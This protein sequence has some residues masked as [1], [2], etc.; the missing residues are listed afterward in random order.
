MSTAPQRK[1]GT[2]TLRI[3]GEM[4][5]YRAAELKPVLLAALEQP[6]TLDVDLSAVT[7]L[8][9]SGVQLLMMAKK[10]AQQQGQ[11]LQLLAHSPAVLDV[12]ELLNLAA[13][14][15]DPLVIA[16]SPMPGRA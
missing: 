8:D 11:N 15:G 4:T 3:E 16:A 7:E 10:Q 13:Y 2:A 9:S 14:F 12:M 5:I 1:G 6:D